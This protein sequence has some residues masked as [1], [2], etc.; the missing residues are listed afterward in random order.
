MAKKLVP[1]KVKIGLRKDGRAD[2]PDWMLVPCYAQKGAKACMPFGWHY[3]KTSG[4]KENTGDSPY[5][6]QWGMLLVTREF[7]TEAK[8]RFPALVTELTETEA[9]DFWDNKAYAHLPENKTHSEE[10]TGLQAELALHKELGSPQAK[11]DEV[12]DRIK[13]ALDP[14][15]S[16]IG[17]NKH[18]EKY[19]EDAKKTK[20]FEMEDGVTPI[21]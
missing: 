1:I 17:I 2:H 14:T 10:L 19:F 13:I 3:D 18:K 6:Q 5:G 21:Q 4:H 20:D 9:K 7:A 15:N 16:T 12:K 11:I 8:L